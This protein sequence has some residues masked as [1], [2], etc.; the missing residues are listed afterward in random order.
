MN[1]YV[2]LIVIVFSFCYGFLLYYLNNIQKKILL[3]R[4]L[5]NKVLIMFLY[6]NIMSL[7][8]VFILIKIN[9][10]IL[11]IYFIMS[12]IIGYLIASVHKTST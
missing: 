11:H 9:S 6:C 4:T 12:L 2:Q 3:H 7:L 5:F 10:G 8:Y 1:S